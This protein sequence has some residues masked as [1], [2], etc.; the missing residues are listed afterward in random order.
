MSQDQLEQT[1]AQ[2]PEVDVEDVLHRLESS[3]LA[4]VVIRQ[5]QRF[6]SSSESYYAP[7]DN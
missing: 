1:I 6:W 3:G 4:Q 5:G 7:K 2:Q